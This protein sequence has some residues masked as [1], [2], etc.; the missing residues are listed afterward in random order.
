M[1]EALQGSDGEWITNPLALKNLVVEYFQQLYTGD[2]KTRGTFV[3]GK[4]PLL[5]APMFGKLSSR[6]SKEE[7]F[8]ALKAMGPLKAPGPDGF[9]AI[10]YQQAW[11][12]VG[13]DVSSA[14]IHILEGGDFHPGMAEALMVLIPKGDRPE[15]VKQ[16]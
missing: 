16:F 10:F 15:T 13:N 2:N 7:V 6:Y 4:F 12:I 1:V 11:E 3:T 5:T 8:G 14:T 9:P